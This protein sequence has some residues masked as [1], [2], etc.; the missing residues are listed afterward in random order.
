MADFYSNSIFWVDI[1]KIHPNPYQPRREFEE[2]ALKDLAES[3]RLY[4]VMQPLTVSRVEREKQEGGIAVEYELIAGERRMRASKL[5]GL[6][7]VPVII[8][9]GDTS[10]EKLEL[11]IIENLQRADL[12]PV[13]RA[14]AFARLA[15]EFKLQHGD[16]GKKMG[17]S[18]EYVSNTLRILALPEEML[19]ALASGRIT[20]GHT[21]PLL[22]LTD[23]PEEQMVLFKEIL[24]K[25]VTVRE[26]ERAAR[27]IAV[28]R[29]RRAPRQTDPTLMEIEQSLQKMLGERVRVEQ[30]A[31]GGRVTISFLNP[32]E[33]K[34][35][36]E[37]FQTQRTAHVTHVAP[38]PAPAPM[39]AAT[40]V[41]PTPVP[42]AVPTQPA[43]AVPVVPA[44]APLPPQIPVA[45]VITSAPVVSQAAAPIVVQVPQRVVESVSTPIATT[46]S[47]SVPEVFALEI[48]APAVAP[49]HM[50]ATPVVTEKAAP[51]V[52]AASPVDESDLYSINSFSL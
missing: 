34:T 36:M 10:Q 26:A 28:E 7:Q 35:I 20:E 41:A 21:R 43:V 25:K 15:E 39:P 48:E 14:K 4:G 27:N 16:I 40:Y 32:D 49:V 44:T 11:A 13:E 30:D 37:Q 2:G 9:V 24:N 38:T 47:A 45:P 3:I 29:A 42:I 12:N 31:I 52:A 23:R 8:R 17:R 6:K 33:L 22:M 1:D 51:V 46:V 5:A 18:R 50:P 19:S